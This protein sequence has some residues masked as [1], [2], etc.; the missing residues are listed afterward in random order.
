MADRGQAGRVCPFRFYVL[1]G[2]EANCKR[3]DIRQEGL[4]IEELWGEKCRRDPDDALICS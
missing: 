3:G 4:L 1:N 2:I